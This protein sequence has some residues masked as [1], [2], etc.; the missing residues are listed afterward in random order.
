LRKRSASHQHHNYM[1]SFP[2][3]I[4]FLLLAQTSP[5]YA[6]SQESSAVKKLAAA[7]TWETV[8][9]RKL[10]PRDP[11]KGW[12]KHSDAVHS[13]IWFS[14]AEPKKTAR[15]GQPPLV[16]YD[17]R[18]GDIVFSFMCVKTETHFDGSPNKFLD[19]MEQGVIKSYRRNGVNA[20]PTPVANVEYLHT[21]GRILRLDVP[22]NKTTLMCDLTT[23]TQC[24]AILAA[25]QPGEE[26]EA[27]FQNFI[28]AIRF[29][30]D[31][32]AARN[33]VPP[34]RKL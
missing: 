1:K 12:T 32:T 27:S 18:D 17:A 29:T 34:I 6:C 11:P 25:G 30:S 20:M 15:P 7:A 8:P 16:I 5:P 9:T 24:Y 14:P 2:V 19:A 10:K 3:L 21:K 26:L 28:A 23:P 13:V 22:G 4:A 31:D 33:E